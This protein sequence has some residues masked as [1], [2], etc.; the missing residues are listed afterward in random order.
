MTTKAVLEGAEVFHATMRAA[1]ARLDAM[2]AGDASARLV[3]QA[4]AV[5]APVRSGR[6]STSLRAGK[7]DVTA[8]VA[9]ST[10]YALV[11]E[12]GGGN[13]IPAQPYARPAL[14]TS[15]PAIEAL[16]RGECVTVVNGVHGT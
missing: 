7:R 4:A 15:Q 1:I 14:S 8:Y 11:T 10:D 13:N 5:R 12:Y 3:A 9:S 16:Y 6:L 2:R